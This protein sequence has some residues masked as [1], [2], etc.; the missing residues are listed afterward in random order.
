MGIRVVMTPD[1]KMVTIKNKDPFTLTA[2]TVASGGSPRTYQ[3]QRSFDEKNWENVGREETYTEKK[4]FEIT[5][6][7]RRLISSGGCTYEGDTITVRF[8]KRRAA[9]INPHLRQRTTDN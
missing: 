6:Y 8:K 7:Y 3:W 9:Y 1:E 2:G 5:V 4:P